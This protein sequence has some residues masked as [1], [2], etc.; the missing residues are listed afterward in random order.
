M[1]GQ[2][3]S[4]VGKNPS[5]QHLAGQTIRVLIFRLAVK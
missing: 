2:P 3:I 4:L 1:G 5:E